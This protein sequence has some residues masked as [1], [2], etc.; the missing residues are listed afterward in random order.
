MGGGLRESVT[1]WNKGGGGLAK[2]PGAGMGEWFCNSVTKWHMVW[3][4]LK[5]ARKVWR[6]IWMAPVTSFC[7]PFR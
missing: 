7:L 4:D 6:I 3:E 2:V 1:K 5:Q